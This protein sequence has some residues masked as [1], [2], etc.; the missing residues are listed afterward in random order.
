M[1]HLVPLVERARQAFRHG[2]TGTAEQLCREVLELAPGQRGAL[3]ILYRLCRAAG[4]ARAAEV[5]L[6][7]LVRLHPNEAAL[8]CELGMMLLRKGDLAGAE[9]QA[10]NAIRIAPVDIAS[11]N[12][13]GMVL[14]EGNRAQDGEYHYRRVLELS[15]KR[16]PIVLANLAWCLKSQSRMAEAR[17]LYEESAAAAPDVLQTLLGWARLEEADREFEASARLLAR[18]ELLQPGHA[19]VRLARAVLHGRTRQYAEALA[20]L[21]AMPGGEAD[22]RALDAHEWLEKGRLLDKLGRYDEAFAAFAQG[23]RQARETGGLTYLA[24]PAREQARRL[25][26]FFTAR[27]IS[28]TPHAATVAGPQPLF[29]LGFPRSG[30]TLMEQTLSAHPNIRAG[31]ELPIIND[32]TGIMP[33]VL[34]SPLAYP[35]ALAELWMGDR[36]QGLDTLRDFYLQ[37]ARQIGAIDTSGEDQAPW[38]TDKMPLNE[39][40][41]GLI[42]LLFP[43]SPLVHV[44]RHPLDV[45]LSVFS[46]HLTHG[47]RCAFDLESIA[48]H[49]A[50]TAD[51]VEHYRAEMALRYLP[52]RYEDLVGQQEPTVR[53]VLDFIGEDYEPRCLRFEENRRYARTASYAQVAEKLYSHSLGRYRNYRAHLEKLLPILGP[54]IERLGYAVEW[55]SA[56]ALAA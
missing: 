46:N 6:R 5:L 44:R 31:D 28:F 26:S 29:V 18:A 1:R 32:I 8:T 55:D 33:R 13:L 52:V 38:F 30:T 10:R 2:Q 4:R 53:R 7:R 36:R 42:A 3:E 50:L 39:M 22:S 49:Y 51:L 37:R 9:V 40:H 48:R 19:G 11:H 47:Y 21:E 14:T 43:N 12:L 41:L 16:D 24:E 23:K 54:V 56:Q 27:R 17:A 45:V 15:G 35:E 20:L 25:T 34:G